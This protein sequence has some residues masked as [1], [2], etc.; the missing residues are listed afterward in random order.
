[1]LCFRA[2]VLTSAA[3]CLFLPTVCL[4]GDGTCKNLVIHMSD[5]NSINSSSNSSF[6]G[7]GTA[8]FICNGSELELRDQVSI[9]MM[10]STT[11]GLCYADFSC[12][13]LEVW[14]GNFVVGARTLNASMWEFLCSGVWKSLSLSA[15]YVSVEANFDF[16]EVKRHCR[17][18]SERI[19]VGAR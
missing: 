4:G 14:G 12:G 2:K 1:M 19:C 13:N 15:P 6:S 3:L 8:V 11:D 17:K 7:E 16:I 9:H 5:A 10:S 18:L